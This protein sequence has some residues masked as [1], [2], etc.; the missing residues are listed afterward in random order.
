AADFLRGAPRLTGQVEH[1]RMALDYRQRDLPALARH[2][3]AVVISSFDP[4]GARAA[5]AIRGA[6]PLAP[7]VIGLPGRL[8]VRAADPAALP[9]D[10]RAPGSGPI[11][12]WVPVW[13]A[14][15]LL[16]AVAPAGRP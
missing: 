7:G 5:A 16:A 10:L 3:L 8:G 15:A 9:D 13:L 4:V 12:P 14:P 2:P 1:D 11:S 6:V